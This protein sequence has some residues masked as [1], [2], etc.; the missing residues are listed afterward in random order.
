MF[1]GTLK[2]TLLLVIVFII[3]IGIFLFGS[4][5]LDDFLNEKKDIINTISL[6]LQI[7]ESI[8]S[9]DQPEMRQSADVTM[10][11]YVLMKQNFCKKRYFYLKS[12]CE[13]RELNK[14]S[15][16]ALNSLLEAGIQEIVEIQN[17]GS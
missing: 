1:K 3:G 17:S 5:H 2:K 9:S 11:K 8:Q 13:L 4:P 14:S 12:E 15:L 6:K 16:N 7:V 10:N